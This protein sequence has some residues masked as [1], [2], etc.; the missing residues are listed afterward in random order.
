MAIPR[1]RF[2]SLAGGLAA[3][4][5]GLSA[6]GSNTGRPTASS[7]ASASGSSG[8]ASVA[9]SQ[10]YHEYGENGVED[11]VKRYA[12][13]YDQAKVTVKWNPGEYEKLVSA[14]LLTANVPDVF[15]YGNGPTLDMIKAGQVLDLT[16]TL[17]DAKSQFAPSVLAAMTYDDKIW[18]IPQTVDMQMLYY[19]KSLLEKAGVQPP[20][21]FAD[22]VT[23]AR[24]VQTKDIGGFFAGN[25]G[26]IGVLGNM[27]IWAAG[28]E[29]ISD[30]KTGIGFDDPAMYDA[31]SQWRDFSKDGVLQ[32]AS[33]D[34][35]DGSPFI[36]EETAMQW[37]GLW[38]LPDVQKAFDDDFGVVPFPALGTKGRQ[39]VPFGAFSSC[40]S[41]KGKNPDAAK[42]F[43]KWLWVDSED[44]QV[45]FSNSYGT[46]IP[47]KPSLAPKATKLA[48][49]AGAD[50][51]TFVTDFGHAPNLLWTPAL[52]Q[53]YTAALS[54][55]VRKNAD[56]KSEIAKVATKGQAE[57]KRV[58]G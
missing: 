14:A 11:A 36:N 6:C 2:L 58:K 19:R 49:G 28:F 38:V 40:V 39:A 53:A 5:G 27:F 25:D 47:A 17:G 20:Q 51:A 54:N 35:F 7:S 1:R 41:A 12:A 26:G 57:I 18:A 3:T 37:T 31:L 21:T 45:D 24:A 42:A 50:A 48:A 33:K 43:A 55:I 16:D 34:W 46:H 30:D 22:L 52:T 15:E 13:A 4:A 10:W 23:A 44:D 56:P 32:S 9:L 29:Q 8:T